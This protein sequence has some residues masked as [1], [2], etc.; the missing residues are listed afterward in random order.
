MT[1]QVSVIVICYNQRRTIGR[2]LDSVLAQQGCDYEVI[3]GDD[4]STDGTREVCLEY[5][6]RFPERVRLMPTAPNKGVV[7][8]YF[9]CLDAARGTYV[10]DCAGDD[11]WIGSGR[12]AD[13]CAALD[14]RPDANVVYTDFEILD[15]STGCRRNAGSDPAYSLW[16]GGDTRGRSLLVDIIARTGPLP[17]LLS[18]SIYR[19]EALAEAMARRP[20]LV[21][22]PAF[23]CEDLPVMAALAAAA[24]AIYLPQVT[25]CYT[26]GGDTITNPQSVERRV[27]FYCRSLMATRVLACAYDVPP[28]AL[29]P[30]FRSLARYVASLA[31]RHRRSDLA[32]EAARE[33]RRWGLWPGFRAAVYLLLGRCLGACKK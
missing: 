18:A 28:S 2:A 1:P 23:G 17:Y 24:P 32:A 3:I 8:N 22:Q 16:L 10:A 29:G 27:G 19:R 13:M 33:I 7:D 20:G 14:R 21:R 30:R 5:E 4:A 11:Y 9:D 6:R 15:E 25:M 26:L 31:W 12:L